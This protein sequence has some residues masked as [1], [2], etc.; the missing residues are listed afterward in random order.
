MSPDPSGEG[1]ANPWRVLGWE[2]TPCNGSSM[3]NRGKLCSI[4]EQ[5]HTGLYV[6]ENKAPTKFPM[7]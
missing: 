5:M 6:A 4:P 3:E 1:E 2:H 7:V